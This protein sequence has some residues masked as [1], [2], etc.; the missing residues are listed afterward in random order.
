ME[1]LSFSEMSRPRHSVHIVPQSESS[2][3][4]KA[5]ILYY[6]LKSEFL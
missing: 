5:E 1:V 2:K 4:Q 6:F 3:Q